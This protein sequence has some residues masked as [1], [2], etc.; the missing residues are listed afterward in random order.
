MSHDL[1]SEDIVE[2]EKLIEDSMEISV[3]EAASVVTGR[4][5]SPESR[6]NSQ[7]PHPPP[8]TSEGFVRRAVPVPVPTD[9]SKVYIIS[10]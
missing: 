8:R 3:H 1:V 7:A 4:L 2:D 9:P 5:Y 10:T 6:P